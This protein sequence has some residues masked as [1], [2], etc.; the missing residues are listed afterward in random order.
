MN[1]TDCAFCKD[2]ISNCTCDFTNKC[3]WCH[4]A[5]LNCY[6]ENAGFVSL[7]GDPQ[8]VTD[9]APVCPTCITDKEVVCMECGIDWL[10]CKCT[11]SGQMDFVCMMCQ[12]NFIWDDISEVAETATFGNNN[13]D[14]VTPIKAKEVR[15]SCKPPKAFYCGKCG[16]TRSHMSEPWKFI[17]MVK[18]D[19]KTTKTT[20][21]ATTNYGSGYSSSHTYASWWHKCRHYEEKVTFPNGVE[22]YASSMNDSRSKRKMIP[23]FSLYADWSW[24]PSWRNEHIDWPDFDIP[25]DDD[26]ALEAIVDMYNKAEEGWN[27]EVGCIG[28][29]GRTGTILAVMALL[30]GIKNPNEAIVW[31][32]KNYCAE[33]IESGIQEWWVEWAH[34]VFNGEEAPQQPSRTF[35]STGNTYTSNY[36]SKSSPSQ[37]HSYSPCSVSAHYAT[38]LEGEVVCGNRK[39]T[40]WKN[41]LANFE[42][43]K[44]PNYIWE[45]FEGFK[46]AKL[47]PD[48]KKRTQIDVGAG[49]KKW[50]EQV[51][52]GS[53]KSDSIIVDGFV[54]PKPSKGETQHDPK[55]ENCRCDYC[56]YTSAGHGAFLEEAEEPK[57]LEKVKIAQPGG[58]IL[59]INVSKDWDHV[60]PSFEAKH[61]TVSND[62]KWIDGQGWVWIGLLPEKKRSK[63]K[64]KKNKGYN[65]RSRR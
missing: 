21:K 39:C 43:G 60:P 36:T 58:E 27:V 8:I 45:Q 35:R 23:D 55:N 26:S 63:K 50:V 56:R 19:S 17:S 49:K 37:N 11:P 14:N 62:F 42:A 34:S 52:P 13:S 54:L 61:G 29:H 15:C 30:S 25:A 10:A 64:N 2:A 41:D 53:A 16:V 22:I 47:T 48:F 5:A 6:C 32:R 51:D 31:V 46:E 3:V 9:W 38:F 18:E 59:E 44:V 1:V 28:G 7:A 65:N 12:T 24:H 40:F 57:T 4:D 33:A 20:T